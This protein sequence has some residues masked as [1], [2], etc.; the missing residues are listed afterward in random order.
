MGVLRFVAA[1]FF[2]FL[3]GSQGL[4]PDRAYA[5][6]C[7]CFCMAWCTCAG[8]WDPGLKRYCGWCGRSEDAVSQTNTSVDRSADQLQPVNEPVATTAAK[9]DVTEQIM[10]LMG[11][12]RCLRAKVASSLLGNARDNLMFVPVH[13]KEK[14]APPFLD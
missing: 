13:F 10:H 11:G 2:F 4:Q 9:S 3:L 5:V 1:I 12:G 8:Q 14:D 7:G 6:C